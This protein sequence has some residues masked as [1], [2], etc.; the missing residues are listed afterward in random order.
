MT[1][2]EAI[3]TLKTF[4]DWRRGAEGVEQPGP[5]LIGEAIDIVTNPWVN[6]KEVVPNNEEPVLIC[7]VSRGFGDGSYNEYVFSYDIATY[8]A[9]SFWV[10][11][12]EWGE[13]KEV[14]HYWMPIIN[15][16]TN[17]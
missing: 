2:Q 4:N 9:G 5:K 10:P 15:P 8:R 12:Y 11:D 14:A 17:G 3:K 7:R 13:I 6:A 16:R 1:Y